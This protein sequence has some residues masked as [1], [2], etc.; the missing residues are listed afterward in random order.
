[1]TIVLTV[2]PW[3]DASSLS[4]KENERLRIAISL[5]SET[6]NCVK[7]TT[8][9]YVDLVGDLRAMTTK[10][11]HSPVGGRANCQLSS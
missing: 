9:V 6:T 8:R 7:Q 1:M 11:Q 5:G 2:S 4:T 3:G 10:H